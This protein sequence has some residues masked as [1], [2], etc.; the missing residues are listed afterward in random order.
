MSTPD[1]FT[2]PPARPA[3]S[4]AAP[5]CPR[6][7]ILSS[8]ADITCGEACWHARDEV[9]RCSCNGRNH[10]CLNVAGAEKPTRTAKIDGERWTLAGVTDTRETSALISRAREMNG[11]KGITFLFAHSARTHYGY[12]PAAI[13]R[14]ATKSALAGWAELSAFK[15]SPCGATLLWVRA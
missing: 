8:W 13:I 6:A 11:A 15:A 1:L 14:P 7:P 9:C 10:G 5:P 2:A 3:L 4:V 12:S